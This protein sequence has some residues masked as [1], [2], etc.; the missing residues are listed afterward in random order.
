MEK[1]RGVGGAAALAGNAGII[2]VRIA[3]AAEQRLAR[4]VLEQPALGADVALLEIDMTLAIEGEAA[5]HAI[6]T[7]EGVLAKLRGVLRIGH[8]LVPAATDFGRQVALDDQV[9]NVAL[10][11]GGQVVPRVV[12]GLRK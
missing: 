8:G 2:R 4:L 11:A 1:W 3:V 10:D 12:H 9:I 7:K 5:H 6:A